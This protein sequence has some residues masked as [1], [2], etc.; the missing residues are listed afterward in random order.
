AHG[1]TS[2]WSQNGRPSCDLYTNDDGY[3]LAERPYMIALR[4][5]LRKGITGPV[6]NLGLYIDAGGKGI[7]ATTCVA[8]VDDDPKHLRGAAC[9]DYA[10]TPKSGFYIG[11]TANFGP[12][13][14]RIE[15]PPFKASELDERTNVSCLEDPD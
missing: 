8:D 14:G 12:L 5:D 4:N 13:T 2:N 9:V 10:P 1:V 6:A 7:V 3:S 15:A 11:Q